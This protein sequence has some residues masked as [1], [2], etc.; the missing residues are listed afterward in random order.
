MHLSHASGAGSAATRMLK[1]VVVTLGGGVVRLTPSVS[2]A[3]PGGDAE[4]LGCT[5]PTPAST[6]STGCSSTTP[7]PTAAAG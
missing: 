5:S 7:S 2:Y 1:H 4:L 3:G 6:R